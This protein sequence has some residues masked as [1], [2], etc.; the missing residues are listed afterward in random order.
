MP[1]QTTDEEQSV[2]EITPKMVEFPVPAG[3]ALYYLQA[4]LKTGLESLNQSRRFMELACNTETVSQ[5]TD[6]MVCLIGVIESLDE[7][8]LENMK[9][10][11]AQR[12]A[13]MK[14]QNAA[15]LQATFAQD[16]SEEASQE[17]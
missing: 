9:E 15:D 14:A 5:M 3:P 10:L 2:F 13:A 7:V 16:G 4:A 8:G 6:G 17:G 12:L 1:I 11:Q